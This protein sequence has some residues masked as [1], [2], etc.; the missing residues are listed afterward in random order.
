VIA[1]VFILD[2]C[3]TDKFT[4]ILFGYFT[5]VISIAYKAHFFVANAFLLMIYP[6]MFF[7]GFRARW[8]I[9][10]AIILASLFCF[11]VTLSQHLDRIP[12]L[13][14]DGSGIKPYALNILSIS[15][16]GFLKSL[17]SR[18]FLLQRQSNAI[19]DL[20]AAGMILVYTFGLWIAVYLLTS[21]CLKT[22]IRAATFFF[23]LLVSFNYLVMSLGLAL[24]A[25][26]VARPEELLHRPF[27][28]AYFVVVAWAG[29]ALYT[30]LL[31][32]G[33]PRSKSARVVGAI[34]VLFSFSVPLAFARN[35]QALPTVEGFES[36]RTFNSVPCALVEASLYIR[37]HSGVADIIQDSENDPRFVVAALAERQSYAAGW[38][39]RNEGDMVTAQLWS[40]RLPEGL[41]E[42]LNELAGSKKIKDDTGLTEFMQKHRI[43]WYILERTSDVA[44]PASFLEKAVFC[45]DG[46][47]VFH[48]SR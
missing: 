25:R 22:R 38:Q 4:S 48:F 46:Y 43:S 6:C 19:F 11:V 47:R 15:E 26:R 29:A 13:R 20:C 16:P 40:P 8:R 1:W 30:L 41:H 9:I 5:L 35:I 37:N 3:K 27:V 17:F 21:V 34:F 7:P 2:G 42:R 45:R 36:Y 33:P 44:W 28:W 10:S 23:P 14:L 12:T 18:A 24:D 31:G 32:N 39:L